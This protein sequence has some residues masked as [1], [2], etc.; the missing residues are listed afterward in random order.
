MQSTMK[1]QILGV[2]DPFACTTNAVTGLTGSKS[3]IISVYR[4]PLPSANLG[5]FSTIM[6]DGREP[7]LFQQSVDATLGHGQANA[8]LT[9]V[10]QQQIVTF[11][12]GIFTAQIHD[13]AAAEL[14]AGSANGGPTALA[15]SVTK[16]FVGI[17]DPFGLNPTGAA[18]SPA[19]FHLYDGWRDLSGGAAQLRHA[20]PSRAASSSST[21]FRTISPGWTD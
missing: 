13:A 21:A 1:F 18:F 20:A 2:D 4:R 16:F 15:T 7:D 17:N 12:A 14:T 11:E 19:I 9:S 5:F 6:W 10:Q 8:A 3:G